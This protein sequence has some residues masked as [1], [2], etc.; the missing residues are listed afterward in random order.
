MAVSSQSPNK[1]AS[2]CYFQVL[3]AN[4]YTIQLRPTCAGVL[5]FKCVLQKLVFSQYY[6]SLGWQ[7]PI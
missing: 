2:L 4:C 6:G 3:K 5:A 1:S 7:F